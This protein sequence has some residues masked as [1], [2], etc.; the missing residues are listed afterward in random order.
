MQFKQTSLHECEW[1][2][3]HFLCQDVIFHRIA[4][5][6][7]SAGQRQTRKYMDQQMEQKKSMTMKIPQ[8][9]MNMYQIDK[10]VTYGSKCQMKTQKQVRDKIL[11]I[12]S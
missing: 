2:T 7:Y 6:N 10:I 11:M 1:S 3:R 5:V 4:G 8:V 9:V 12:M